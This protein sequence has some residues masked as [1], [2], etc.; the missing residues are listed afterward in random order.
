MEISIARHPHTM[1]Q[2][3]TRASY[4]NSTFKLYNPLLYHDHLMTN[5]YRYP[6]ELSPVP[7]ASSTHPHQ[8]HPGLAMNHYQLL[9]AI[10]GVICPYISPTVALHGTEYLNAFT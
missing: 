8:D 1:K 2:P 10:V 4:L 5:S 9:L 6:N 3:I 7:G